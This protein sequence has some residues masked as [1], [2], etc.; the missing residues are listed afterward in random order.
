MYIH[1]CVY[2][3]VC[4]ISFPI[5]VLSVSSSSSSSSM[6]TKTTDENRQL[7]SGSF[8]PS[9]ELATCCSLG[10]FSSLLYSLSPPRR[11]LSISLSFSVFDANLEL[12][13]MDAGMR[14][15]QCVR[16]IRTYKPICNS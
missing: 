4:P 2:T 13:V 11:L 9:N 3:R 15:P 6:R 10:R 12:F 8:T 14:Y 7:D 16:P 5:S 1:I